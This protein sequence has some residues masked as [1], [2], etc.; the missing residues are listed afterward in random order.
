LANK[1]KIFSMF[2]VLVLIFS[3]L[4]G[5]TK[6]TDKAGSTTTAA[7]AT[8]AGSA[9]TAPVAT[10]EPAKEQIQLEFWTINLKK[11]FTPYFEGLI[12]A[13]EQQHTNI[14]INW[15]DVPGA[16]VDAKMLTAL[17]SS[18]V[19]D[20]VNETTDGLGKLLKT[21]SLAPLSELVDKKLLDVYIKGMLEGVSR[22]GKVMALPWYTGGPA[23]SFINTELYAKAGLDPNKPAKTYDELFAYGKQI[24]QKLPK[25]YGSNDIPSIQLLVSE[26]LPVLSPDRKTAVFNSPDHIAYL[27]KFVQAYKDGA[28][29][30]GAVVKDDRQLQQTLDN[31]LT[32]HS[33]QAFATNINNW[34][35]TAPNLMPKLKVVPAVTGKAD[36][37]AIKDFQLFVVPAKSKHPKEAAEFGLYVTSPESQLAF[38]KAV[39]IFPSTEA[40]LKD[41]FFTDVKG[42]TLK[43]E[44][45]KVQVATAS[46]F[47]LSKQGFDN[48]QAAVDNY[49]ENIAAALLGK[50]T[51]KQALD[52]SVKFWNDI[53]AK[54]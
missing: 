14:K 43:D 8:T 39:A 33:G 41:P 50:K 53:L 47:A 24:H 9:T 16:D 31:E 30:P 52:D 40:T 51:S 26:G 19:P 45:R 18:N 49:N 4:V 48:E 12:S 35:K 1:R 32:A 10:A 13:Y 44:A 23:V 15:V 36:K 22:D 11:N 25:V 27:D 5:C 7:P 2:T 6:S 34:E 46:K 54:Q 21:N 29:A 42:T 28:I 37:L 20:V 3:L 17:A 38:C